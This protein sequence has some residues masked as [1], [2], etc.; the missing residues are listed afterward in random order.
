MSI[1][2]FFRELVHSK[3]RHSRGRMKKSSGNPIEINLTL[4]SQLEWFSP[5]STSQQSLQDYGEEPF[6]SSYHR[7]S[8]LRN[9]FMEL[10]TRRTSVKDDAAPKISPDYFMFFC[11]AS[12]QPTQAHYPPFLVA[13]AAD[14]QH[15]YDGDGALGN[16]PICFFVSSHNL[17]VW[18]D[19]RTFLIFVSRQHNL[20]L[21]NVFI[22]VVHMLKVFGNGD[23]HFPKS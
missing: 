13:S 3:I 23:C 17:N 22:H 15:T 1:S 7:L 10:T 12:K 2:Y 5:H 9:F 14:Q 21:A 4:F 18:W 11:S 16:Y 20:T 8:E 6:G 19:S